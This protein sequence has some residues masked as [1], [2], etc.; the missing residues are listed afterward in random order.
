MKSI[1]RLFAFLVVAALLSPAARAEGKKKIVFIAGTPSH[2]Y[3]GHEHNA[4]CLL[5]AKCLKESQLA[6]QL[7]VVV[8]NS[9]KDDSGKW[10]VI[11]PTAADFEGAAAIVI[12][13]DGGNN[14]PALAHLKELDDLARKGVGIGMIHYAVEPGDEK[15]PNNG[16][17][18]FLKWIGGYFETFYSINPHWKA[19]VTSLPNHPVANGV[20]PF[21]SYDEWYYH[22][23]FR[24]NMEGVTPIVAAIPPDSTRKGKDDA[25]GGNEEIR[26][27]LGKSLTEYTVWVSENPDPEYHGQRGFGCTGAHVHW[28]WA[29]DDFRKVILNAIVWIAHVDVPKDGVESK[30]PTAEELM[31]NMDPKNNRKPEQDEAWVEKQI[32]KLNK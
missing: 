11:W 31:A 15:N 17:E 25:H 19:D 26:K 28:N 1:A 8:F 4:G 13:A 3:G 16:R 20:K 2:E 29:Q 5:L 9:K 27:G 30:R 12:Y 23:R 7:D 24:P 21:Q 32:G 18:Y 10:K 22:M 14:H 6:D